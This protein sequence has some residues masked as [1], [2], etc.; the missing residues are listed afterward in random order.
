VRRDRIRVEP[1]RVESDEERSV[2]GAEIDDP[3]KR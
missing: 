2:T 1:L 3:G